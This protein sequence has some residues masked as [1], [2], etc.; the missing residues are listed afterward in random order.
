VAQVALI[1]YDKNNP[2]TPAIQIKQRLEGNGHAVTYIDWDEPAWDYSPYDLIYLSYEVAMGAPMPYNVNKPVGLMAYML[3]D[4]FKLGSNWV[5]YSVWENIYIEDNAHYI[6]KPYS[7][8][9]LDVAATPKSFIPVTGFANDV[10]SLAKIDSPPI[11]SVIAICETGQQ[12]Y[13][14]TIAAARR[15]AYGIYITNDINADGWNLFDRQIVWLLGEEPRPYPV[16]RL[17]KGFVSGHHCFMSN[18]ITAK[19]KDYTPLKLPD[20]TIF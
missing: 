19:V 3:Y 18:Y 1:V 15:A 17:K 4:E 5:V 2:Y 20:G 9:F 12:L 6:T 10:K 11:N 8:G 16:A 13:D 14:G 7:L